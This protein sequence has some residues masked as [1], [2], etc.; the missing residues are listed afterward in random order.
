MHRMMTRTACSL[1]SLLSLCTAWAQPQ[2]VPAEALQPDQ[3]HSRTAMTIAQVLTDYHYSRPVLNDA[4]S[5]LVWQR[6]LDVLDPNRYFFIQSDIHDF[7]QYQHRLDDSLAH[8]LLQPAYLIFKRYRTRVQERVKYAEHLLTTHTFNFNLPERFQ[9]DR[10]DTAWPADTAALDEVW[11]KRI[12]N[13][14]LTEQLAAEKENEPANAQTKLRKRYAAIQRRV[15]QLNA[16]DVFE[17]FINAFT[18]SIE[19]HTGYMSPRLSENFDID[20]R[21]S[22][23]GIGAVLRDDNEHTT[24]VSVVPGGPASKSNALKS[25]DRILGVGQGRQG[26]MQDVVGWRLQDV[27]DLIRG[28][29]GSTVRLKVL[30][31]QGLSGQPR[32]V[33]LIRDEIRLEDKAASSQILQGPAFADKKIGVIDIPTFYRDFAAQSAGQSDFRSTTRDVQKLLEELKT[34]EVDGIV[35]DL[36]GNG[37]GSLAEATGLTGLFIRQGPVVQV[38]NS[39]G[40]IQL[41]QDTDPTQVY[42]GPLAVLVDRHSASASEIFAGA[43]QD[44]G[45]GLVLGETTF[46]KGTVQTLINLQHYLKNV[47]QAG[48]LRLTMAQFFRVEGSST[49]HRGVTPDIIF[50]TSD[51]RDQQG[52]RALDHALPWSRVRPVLAPPATT[53]PALDQLR[54]RHRQRIANDPGFVFLSA[55]EKLFAELTET[56]D[57]SLRATQRR[58]EQKQRE[59]EQLQIRNQLRAHRGLPALT[60]LQASPKDN[61]ADD[62]DPEGIQRIMLDEAALI[63][64]DAIHF[65]G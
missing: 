5:Q 63:L 38:K 16:G 53:L 44:Y 64:A 35:V 13:D 29:K 58:T 65:K 14:L 8:G 48:R 46:G 39:A 49:Q 27:V 28:A 34:A 12:K 26:D 37:G 61:P 3:Q 17:Q 15:L 50:P 18:L 6:Y 57:I 43:M 33:I 54:Q 40:K 9:F 19:P 4:L 2:L 55:Q 7:R 11:R 1:I 25:G 52:E 60:D 22:L 23:Q 24:I 62:K 10:Q 41:E 32:E 56:S 45:R 30:P 20:M 31:K 47:D 51:Q 21:L 36:R 59:A 42:A